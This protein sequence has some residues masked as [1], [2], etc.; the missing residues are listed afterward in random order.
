M[1][2]VFNGDKFQALF[3]LLYLPVSRRDLELRYYGFRFPLVLNY[4]YV[5]STVKQVSSVAWMFTKYLLDSKGYRRS[6]YPMWS[7]QY[8]A[9]Y[10]TIPQ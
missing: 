2:R 4:I 1:R 10:Y 9:I 8:A 3:G 7:K 6:T 5:F